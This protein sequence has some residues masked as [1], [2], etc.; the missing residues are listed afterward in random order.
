MRK[1]I[2]DALFPKTRQLIL[3]ALLLHPER[4]WY[5]SDLAQ[6]IGVRVS[7]LQR[8]LASL[9]A[10]DLIESRKEGNRVY[11][12]AQKASPVLKDLQR[13]LLKTS[14]LKEILERG[15]SKCLKKVPVAFIYG[16]MA[17]GEELSSSDVDLFIIGDIQLMELAPVLKRLEGKLGR[18]INP[19]I[20]SE[21]E[22]IKKLESKDG[23]LQT[24]L[25]DKKIFIKGDDAQ[26]KIL[27]G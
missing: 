16:S 24:V 9:T 27:V 25:A 10:A 17:R 2:Q 4:W 11:Y 18:E 6:R 13:L 22:Y 8:E 20:Y 14:G 21:S 3:S 7:S 26:L 1:S 5:M 15:L 12:R 23:F 19:S